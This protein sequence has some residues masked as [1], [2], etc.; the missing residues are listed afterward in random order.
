MDLYNLTLFIEAYLEASQLAASA[1]IYD[2][3]DDDPVW[4]HP[5]CYVGQLLF[6]LQWN[7]EGESG[8]YLVLEKVKDMS[9]STSDDTIG[10]CLIWSYIHIYGGQQLANMCNQVKQ[11]IIIYNVI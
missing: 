3:D 2:D 10:V 4:W 5:M 9:T 11:Y 1:S 6:W 8:A 7:E